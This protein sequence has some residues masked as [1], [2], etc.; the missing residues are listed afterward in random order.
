[1]QQVDLAIVGGGLVGGGLALALMNQ[2]LRIALIEAK[3]PQAIDPRLFALNA[4][5]CDFLKKMHLWPDLAQHAAAIHAV[6]VS[7]RGHFGTVCLQ[8]DDVGLAALGY[9]IPAKHIEAALHERLHALAT[10]GNLLR[11]QPASL[12]TMETQDDHTLLHVM[13]ATAETLHATLVIGA[14]GTHST[15][16]T[17][18]QF[19]A[20]VHDYQQNAIVTRTTLKR[21]HQQMAYERF[22]D[23]GAI[24][25]LPLPHDE[26]ATIWTTTTAKS[27]E[28][29]A[30]SP[31]AFLAQ[32]QETFGYRLGRLQRIGER[33]VFPLQQVTLEKNV[34]NNVL[35]IGNAA[36]TV[37][38]FAAQGYN[39]ALTEVATLR[40][41]I[42]AKKAKNQPFS[43]ADLQVTAEQLR[44][45]QTLNL[46][47]SHHL[48]EFFSKERWS[49]NIAASLAMVSFNLATPLKKRLLKRLLGINDN[50]K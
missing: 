35:L 31:D 2:G 40:D 33:H 41:A 13:G 8:R 37:H 19:S 48:A 29:M 30:I 16:R 38:P 17:Q 20:T 5:T 9:V 32:L 49:L 22:T 3:L 34:L 23:E 14:D 6:H 42:L 45:Q 15:V 24:A 46:S 7:H 27:A 36:H 18:L 21:G 44:K 4:S 50:D 47:L 26:C 11:Y 12:Q 39:L 10:S 28:L 25:M 1:M 43:A